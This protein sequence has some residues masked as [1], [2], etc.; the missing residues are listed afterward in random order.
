[1]KPQDRYKQERDESKKAR[2][3][4]IVQAAESVFFRKG[5]EGATMNDIAKEAGIG[6][7]TVFRYFPAKEQLVTVLA[8][9][10]M[11]EIRLTFASIAEQN[12]TC[13]EKIGLLF[14]YF[15]SLLEE[16]RSSFIKF[17]ED[18][19]LNVAHARGLYGDVS[20]HGIA[21]RKIFAIFTAMIEEGEKDGSLRS[22]LPAEEM[23]I[24]L[25]NAFGLFASKLAYQ[26]NVL[27]LPS[28]VEPEKQLLLVKEM[29]MAFI[30]AKS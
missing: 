8:D 19:H 3:Q 16:R 28:D 17:L 18:L 30:K 9:G 13:L 27:M 6:V 24:T 12:A 1:M 15:I 14:D 10:I 11:E 20:E 5:I 29:M 4:Q 2:H 21:G 22:D 7:A 23:L 25:V 26:K